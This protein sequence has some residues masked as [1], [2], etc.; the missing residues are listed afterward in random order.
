LAS[1][2]HGSNARRQLAGR[3]GLDDVVVGAELQTDNAID[4]TRTRRQQDHG[5]VRGRAQLTKY[6]EAVDTRQHDVED[7]EHRLV[8]GQ[9]LQ[10]GGTVSRFEHPKAIVRQVTRDDLTHH[11]LVVDDQNAPGIGFGEHGT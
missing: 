11:W 4:F 9:N 5:Y 3:E 10:R 2:K 1:P 8:A 6:R 7:D